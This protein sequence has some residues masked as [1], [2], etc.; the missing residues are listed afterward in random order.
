MYVI[1]SKEDGR[2]FN[3]FDFE[4]VSFCLDVD[5]AVVFDTK[6]NALRMAFA[7]D[8]ICEGFFDSV[9]IKFVEV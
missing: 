3:Y 7:L 1:V 4:G 5:Y 8:S 2:Y 6:V 9:Y